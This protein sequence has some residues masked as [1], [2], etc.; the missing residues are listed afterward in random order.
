VLNDE[1]TK[2]VGAYLSNPSL[3]NLKTW[4]FQPE[5]RATFVVRYVFQIQGQ[6]TSLP[7]NPKVELDLPLFVKVTARPSN[8]HAAIVFLNDGNLDGQFLGESNISRSGSSSP[9]MR[10]PVSV[11]AFFHF[12]FLL[13]CLFFQMIPIEPSRLCHHPSIRTLG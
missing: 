8:P 4:Q 9:S 13:L 1:G 5:D 11:K 7:E 6:E 12:F 10:R 3:A 2:K